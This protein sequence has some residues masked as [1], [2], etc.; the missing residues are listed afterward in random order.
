MPKFPNNY[1]MRFGLLAAVALAVLMLLFPGTVKGLFRAD[2]FM[3][4]ATCYLRNPK[5]MFLHVASDTLAYLV[6]RASKDIPF[7]WMFLAPGVR[8]EV[9]VCRGAADGAVRSTIRDNGIKRSCFW[10]EL[11]KA[12][13]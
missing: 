8:P 9:R 6:Y 11:A 2:Q 7:H 12:H 13:P 4:H 1:F 10:I 3:P 5:M